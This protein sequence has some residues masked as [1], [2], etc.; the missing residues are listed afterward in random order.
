MVT[1]KGFLKKCTGLSYS[2]SP[3]SQ[4]ELRA[5]AESSGSWKIMIQALQTGVLLLLSNI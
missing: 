3:K 1:F 4:D 2:N 5:Q